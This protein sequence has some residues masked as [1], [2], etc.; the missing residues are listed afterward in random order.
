VGC[1]PTKTLIANAQVMHQIKHAADFGI[2]TGAVSFDFAK[3]KQRKD[4]VVEKMRKGLEGLMQSNAITILRGMAEFTGPKE[5]KVKGQDNVVVGAEKIIIATGSEPLD[6]PAFPCDH[7]QVF[8]STSILE[9]TDLPKTLVVIG[10]GYIGCEFASLYAQFG[11]KVIILEALPAILSLQG[12]AVSD[13]M[14]QAFKKQGIDIQTNLFVE[15][16]DKTPSGVSVRVKDKPPVLCDRVLV[17]IGRKFV[18]QGLTCDKA[19]VVVTDKGMIPVNEKMETNV[20]GIYAIGD[21]TGKVLLA[22]VASHQG[23]VAAANACGQEAVMHY[24]AVPAVIFTMPEVATVGMTLE[25]AQAAGY[26]AKTGKFPYL[27]LGKAVAAMETDGFAEI[28]IDSKNGQ[29]LGATAVGHDAANLIAEMAL[30]IANE[31]TVDCLTD[32]IH[33]HP[34]IAEAWLEAAFMAIDT[35][36]NFPPKVRKNT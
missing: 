15:G 11:V 33:A 12:K 24:D 19:G 10:G 28:I 20:P 8:N 23:I 31:L 4:G 2:T 25:Q 14:T 35:P 16:I 17:S 26:A 30:A 21:V 5:L 32:T 22:H 29:I 1:I 9:M 13:V 18:S 3:M 36:I 6:I 34:T 7:K 27:A